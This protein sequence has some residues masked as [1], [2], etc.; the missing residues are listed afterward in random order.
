MTLSSVA[1]LRQHGRAGVSKLFYV[2]N[3]D[4]RQSGQ[5]NDSA[6]IVK[7]AKV[8]DF[9]IAKCS[10]RPNSNAAIMERV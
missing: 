8:R 10:K 3:L 2:N 1:V 5:A 4:V 6:S 9:A 7:R